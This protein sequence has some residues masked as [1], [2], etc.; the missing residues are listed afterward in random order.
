MSSPDLELTMDKAVT[1]TS[2]LHVRLPGRF[3]YACSDPHSVRGSE[4]VLPDIDRFP[5]K[6]SGR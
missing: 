3:P 2:D 6:H 1:V 4:T 5:E